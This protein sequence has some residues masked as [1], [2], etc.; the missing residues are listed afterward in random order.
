MTS[1][2]DRG[3]VAVEWYGVERV[4]GEIWDVWRARHRGVLAAVLTMRSDVTEDQ[5]LA[6]ASRILEQHET[7]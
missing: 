2:P 6:I 4:D 1:F 7:R 5:V 3:D